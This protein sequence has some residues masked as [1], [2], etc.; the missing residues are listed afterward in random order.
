MALE[1][2]ENNTGCEIIPSRTTLKNFTKDYA[3]YLDELDLLP[4]SKNL[5]R[6]PTKK[7]LKSNTTIGP[8][9]VSTDEQED[10]RDSSSPDSIYLCGN[11]LGLQPRRTA[12][13]ILH[14]L[15]TWATQGVHGHFKPLEDSPLPEWLDVDIR[16]SNSMAPILGALPS[17]VVVMQTLTAN[18]HLLMSAFYRPDFHGRHKIIIE[19]QAFP[20][21]HFVA[22]SQIKLHGLDPKDSLIIITPQAPSETLTTDQI[23]S[24]IEE[25][26]PTTSVILFPGIQYYT[27]QLFD[28]QAINA[29]A[30]KAG[31]F[32]IWDLAHA[33]GNVD[34]R[35]HDWNIDAA[36]W[37]N[38]K[39][40]NSGPG[41]SGG[42]F[43]HENHSNV[44]EDHGETKYIN[45]LSG[46]WGSEKKSRFAMDNRFKP[47]PGAA[48]FQLSNPSVLD[49]TS[50]IGSLEV[51]HEACRWQSTDHAR[52]EG[53]TP[54][55][56]KSIRLT[57]Y[58]E[59]GLHNMEMFKKGMFH[60]ITPS[61]PNQRGAQLSLKL[62]PDLLN[63]VMK[64]LE[65]RGI[66]VDERKPDVIRVAPNPLYNT[67]E[68]CWNFIDAFQE[69]LII[70]VKAKMENLLQKKNQES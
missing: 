24:T 16:A 41:V 56:K 29:A 67:F 34:L 14:Y 62:K 5:F 9:L 65:E 46:W 11:S 42:L 52:Q 12:S 64:E 21:D 54:L 53:I 50:V 57:G 51:F 38:Y 33:A 36:V 61:D 66:V 31:I 23:I 20:S 59:A 19:S 18:L 58:L 63:I 47:I 45:R 17:E 60:I 39:Y 28:I 35:L 2:T 22:E 10:I 6:I 32:A 13:L 40:L 55:R 69:A 3:T 43:I 37:C 30:Q 4:H 8:L 70:A 26:G 27:G 1:N 49:L 7:H 25:H 15:T 44:S 48:G 68:D